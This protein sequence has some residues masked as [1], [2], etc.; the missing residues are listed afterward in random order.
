[1]ISLFPRSFCAPAAADV[2]FTPIFRFLD[3]FD[4]Y[5]REAQSSKSGSAARRHHH[6]RQRRSQLSTFNPKFDVRETG[7][8]YELHGELPG[9]NRENVNIEFADA[10]TIVISGRFERRY[11]SEPNTTIPTPTA[12]NNNNN[13]SSSSNNSIAEAGEAETKEPPRI[14]HQATVEDDPEDTPA[15]TPGVSTPATEVAKLATE[16]ET[17]QAVTQT[18]TQTEL[19]DEPKHWHWGRSVGE[20]S[21]AFTF[22]ARVDHDRVAASLNNGILSVTVPKSR[23]PVTMRIEISA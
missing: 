9:L 5:S 20:F 3:E 13:S 12:T 23:R 10:Q 17:S 11:G 7:E 8:T 21:R 4:T 14:S 6:H 2:R 1:M 22:Q 19:Q 15:S 18:Q 16:P